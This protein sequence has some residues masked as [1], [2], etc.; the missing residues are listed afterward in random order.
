MPSRAACPRFLTFLKLG[1][2]SRGGPHPDR[3]LKGTAATHGTEHACC[4]VSAASSTSFGSHSLFTRV[5]ASWAPLSHAR[6]TALSP[7][8]DSTPQALVSFT[9]P[10]LKNW[11]RRAFG[12]KTKAVFPQNRHLNPAWSCFS[13]FL[14]RLDLKKFGYGLQQ[15]PK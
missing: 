14:C 15:P 7:L 10:H 6:A 12:T 1:L 11:L 9:S 5:Q 8:P 3:Q 4:P 13:P 2:Q